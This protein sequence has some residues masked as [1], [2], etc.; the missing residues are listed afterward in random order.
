VTA[1]EASVK[2]LA[3][4]D[5]DKQLIDGPVLRATCDPVSGSTDDLT[6]L[7]TTFNCFVATKDNGDGTSTGYYFNATMNWD[8]GSYTYGLGKAN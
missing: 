4:D 1:I 5:V 7:T 2:K 3:Q 8:S 6:D